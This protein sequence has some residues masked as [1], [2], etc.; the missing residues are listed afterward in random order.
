MEFYYTWHLFVMRITGLLLMMFL[1][2]SCTRTYKYCNCETTDGQLKAYNDVLNE[3]I[4]KHFYNFYLG[5]DEERIFKAYT[6]E[7][8]DT[9]KINQMVIRLQNNLFEDSLRFATIYLDTLIKP[10]FDQLPSD[11]VIEGNQQAIIDQ[12]NSSQQQYAPADFTLCTAKMKAISQLETDTNKWIIGK[13]SLS[14]ISFNTAQDKG[15]LY[16]EY[17]CGYLCGK[18]EL[19]MIAKDHNRWHIIKTKNMWF[20]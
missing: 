11:M 6:Q 16:C 1:C 12:L 9:A 15:L 8:A 20:N 14:E 13:I 4:E 17:H 7:N 3:L 19:L 10:A 5:E 18:G 2:L